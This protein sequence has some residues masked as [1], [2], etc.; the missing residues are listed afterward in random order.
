MSEHDKMMAFG[1]WLAER[2]AQAR[3]ELVQ[4]GGSIKYPEAALRV[5]SGQIEA[6]DLTFTAFRDLYNGDLNKFMKQYLGRQLEGDDEEET[7]GS[8]EGPT[9]P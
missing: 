9:G 7:D 2:Q 4:M 1:H 6:F 5:K 3:A 8:S